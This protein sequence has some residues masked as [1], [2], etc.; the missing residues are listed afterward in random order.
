MPARGR[1]N[2]RDGVLIAL[3]ASGLVTVSITGGWLLGQHQALKAQGSPEGSSER[4][5][6]LLQARLGDGSASNADQQRLVD[7]L[8]Q[9]GQSQEA[10]LVLER[11]AD[12]QPQNWQLRLLLAELRR[13]N[14]DRP[15]AERELRQILNLKPDRIEALQLLTLIQLEQGRGAAAEAQLKTLLEASSKPTPQPQKLGLGLLLGDLR[16]RQGKRADALAL[17]GQLAKDFP[18]DPRPLLA[19]A[20]LKQDQGD[21]AGAGQALADAQARQPEKKDPRLDRVAA[22]WGLDSL[23]ESKKNAKEPSPAAKKPQS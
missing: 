23:R 22:S 2:Q 12:Q 16:Q 6:A 10:S 3:V 21:L 11:L 5:I 7:L 8:I 9:Q 15:G 19:I 14:N 20:L 1:T 13:N 17:Y 4:Q 18:R